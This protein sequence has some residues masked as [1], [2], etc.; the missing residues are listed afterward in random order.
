MRS[1][2]VNPAARD[3]I[4]AIIG[5]VASQS[6]INAEMLA[7]R[8]LDDISSLADFPERC[9]LALESDRWGYPVRSMLVFRYRLLFT[10]VGTRVHILRVVHGSMRSPVAPP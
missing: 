7:E 8:F 1:V 5:F 4:D 3:D 9:P 2:F 6:P 10:I